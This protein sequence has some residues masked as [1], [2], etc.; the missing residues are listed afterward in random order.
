MAFTWTYT[1]APGGRILADAVNEIKNNIDSIAS[2][3]GM[4]LTWNYNP[5]SPNQIIT[6]EQIEELRSNVDTLY[7]C[8]VDAVDAYDSGYDGVKSV[9]ADD[10]VCSYDSIDNRDSVDNRDSIDSRD[11]VDSFDSVEIGYDAYDNFD[12]TVFTTLQ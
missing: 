10:S 11:S 8:S 7:D 2:R 1:F 4:S 12:G 3:V 6:T 9:D 5:V